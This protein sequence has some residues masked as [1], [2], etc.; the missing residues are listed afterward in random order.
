MNLYTITINHS[1]I[2]A[3]LH[4]K[5][6]LINECSAERFKGNLR[7]FG[8]VTNSQLSVGE[9]NLYLFIYICLCIMYYSRWRK[10]AIAYNNWIQVFMDVLYNDERHDMRSLNL[11]I[12]SLE[13]YVIMIFLFCI[14][15]LSSYCIV[16]Q[17]R[18]QQR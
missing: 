15:Y 2:S 11:A 12:K 13:L 9:K 14:C 3:I 1:E 17:R 6:Q 7:G 4:D 10:V 18:Q 8:R 16:M 5:V